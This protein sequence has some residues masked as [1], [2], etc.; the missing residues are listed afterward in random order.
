M[1]E[2]WQAN[3]HGPMGSPCW[4]AI[5]RIEGLRLTAG[6][7]LRSLRSLRRNRPDE[8][9]GPRDTI[10]HLEERGTWERSDGPVRR[11]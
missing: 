10:P 6:L 8:Q 4:Y 9:A 2:G 1:A 7:R 11:P 3:A 5:R